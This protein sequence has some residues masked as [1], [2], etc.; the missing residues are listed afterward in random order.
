MLRNSHILPKSNNT[1]NGE[2]LV[3]SARTTAAS[4]MSLSV[5]KIVIPANSH[6][7]ASAYQPA[8]HVIPMTTFFV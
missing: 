8:A 4:A 3:Q 2:E 7:I 1:K 5:S 6:S